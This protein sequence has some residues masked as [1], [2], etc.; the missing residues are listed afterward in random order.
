MLVT[1]ADYVLSLDEAH[2]VLPFTGK[3]R[4][5]VLWALQ[6]S[7]HDFEPVDV[8]ASDIA[9]LEL[10]T[11]LWRSG[12]TFAIVEHDVVVG[13]ETLAGF[14]TCPHEW[15]AAKYPYL[16]GVYWGLGCTRFRSP[17]LQRFPDLMDE[18]AAYEAPNHP[19]GH[20]CV[21][22]MALTA[23][24]RGHRIEWP[25]QEHGEVGHLSEGPTHG[26][27]AVTQ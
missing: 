23:V 14:D 5:E 10:L 16:R 1:P 4:P 2:V 17:L 27:R 22:D 20:W 12:E 21:L 13:P 15:C 25:H 24:L 6:S 7:E 11:Y 3:L 8:S 18:V 19:P 26:C 9:Y